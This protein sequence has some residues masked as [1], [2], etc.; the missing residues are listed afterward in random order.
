MEVEALVKKFKKESNTSDINNPT[1]Y[2][3]VYIR[4]QPFI[5][6]FK[7]SEGESQKAS[8][9]SNKLQFLV[10][11]FDPEHELTHTSVTQTVSAKWVDIW[12]QYDWVEDLVADSLRLGV[13]V[14]GQDY[15]VSRMGWAKKDGEEEEEESS[16]EETSSEEGDKKL[17]DS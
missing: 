15:V 4:I 17:G 13:E 9:P 8:D 3:N 10:Y 7:V 12:D 2:S 6:R 5:N 1:T 16:E 14:L 11:L